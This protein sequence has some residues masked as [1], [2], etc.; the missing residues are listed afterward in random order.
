MKNKKK[1]IKIKLSINNPCSE[2]W[3]LMEKDKDSRFCEKCQKHVMDFTNKRADEIL[4]YILS[5]YGKKICGRFYPYQL[6]TTYCLNNFSRNQQNKSKLLHLLA[7]GTLFFTYC[8]TTDTNDRT[9][10]NFEDNIKAHQT[11]LVESD[12]TNNYSKDSLT[13]KNCNKNKANNQTNIENTPLVGEIEV[14]SDMDT[15]EHNEDVAIYTV[16]EKMP[17]FKGGMDMLKLFIKR[18]LIY[19]EWEKKNQIEGKVFVKFVVNKEG[20]IVDPEIIKSV[21]G[22]KNFDAEVLRLL[23]IMPDWIPGEHNGKKVDVYY[24][25]PINFVLNGMKE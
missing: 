13:N 9:N 12:T 25:L 5:N 10:N 24:C 11:P 23:K 20:K 8:N 3:D 1:E 17:E 15:S 2:K 22:S 21:P 18:N 16:V 4:E 7:A 6:N 19:P 14:I